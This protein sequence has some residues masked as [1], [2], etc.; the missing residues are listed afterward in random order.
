MGRRG[1]REASALLRQALGEHT[2][3]YYLRAKGQEWDAYRIAVTD[4]EIER[5]LELL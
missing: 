3:T 1:D 2:T 5:Y 4:W